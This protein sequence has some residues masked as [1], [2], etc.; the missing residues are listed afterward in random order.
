MRIEI[1]SAAKRSNSTACFKRSCDNQ[2]C[3]KRIAME[4]EPCSQQWVTPELTSQAI[5]CYQCTNHSRYPGRNRS[6]NATKTAATALWIRLTWSQL[7]WRRSSDVVEKKEMAGYME[8]GIQR[9]RCSL[10]AAGSAAVASPVA[11]EGWDSRD[12]NLTIST[13][14]HR[15]ST[16]LSRA[17][18]TRKLNFLSQLV[19]FNPF[20][21]T[22]CLG[23]SEQ[24]DYKSTETF[25]WQMIPWRCMPWIQ[26][27]QRQGTDCHVWVVDGDSMVKIMV[28]WEFFKIRGI[29]HER[30][31]FHGWSWS[32]SVPAA[33]PWWVQSRV[34]TMRLH[35]ASEESAQGGRPWQQDHAPPAQAPL[36]C[37]LCG[38]WNCIK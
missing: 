22:F 33:E 1:V 20:L 16:A 35:A 9:K 24:L 15:I 31:G 34:V 29:F 6:W 8:T 28:S 3:R 2:N 5:R 32:R 37:K 23:W 4:I 30:Q 11:S 25:S 12:N 13:C 27:W 10:S 38:P 19:V 36:Y 14:P 26:H 17:K 7:Q 21:A 18:R